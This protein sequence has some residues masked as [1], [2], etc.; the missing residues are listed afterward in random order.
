MKGFF[1]VH[2]NYF[3]VS[4]GVRDVK[5]ALTMLSPSSGF[6]KVPANL[7]FKKP[8][9][10]IVLTVARTVPGSVSSVMLMDR[11]LVNLGGLSL[12]SSTYKIK[13]R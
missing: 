6:P 3:S 7:K 12:M 11:I 10:S 9:L 2:P 5:I 13:V 4:E 1:L 8:F